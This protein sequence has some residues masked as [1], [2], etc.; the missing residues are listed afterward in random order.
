MQVAIGKGDGALTFFEFKD[1]GLSTAD[2]D[3]ARQHKQKGY[4]CSETEVPLMSLDAL[5]GE[6]ER[7][8]IHWLKLDVEGLEKSILESWQLAPGRPWIL[9]IESTIPSTQ[10]TTHTDWESLVLSKGYE[11]AYFDGLNRFYVS[12]EQPS[13]KQAFN[14]PPNIFDGFALSGLASQ[15]FCAVVA[16]RAQKAEEQAQHALERAHDAEAQAQQNQDRAG[17]AET[18]LHQVMN[19]RSWRLTAP[20]RWGGLR[21]RRLRAQGFSALAKTLI[22]KTGRPIVR[23]TLAFVNARPALR[24]R[25]VLV[26]HQLGLYDRLRSLYSK[27]QRLSSPSPLGAAGPHSITELA[28]LSPHAL[29]VYQDL[30]DAIENSKKA[31]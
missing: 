24:Q 6:F 8:P 19:S 3:I 26:I 20:L 15:P 30:E 27:L 13:L 4:A 11:F 12:K 17:R 5:L 2:P 28:D 25:C 31:H 10:T 16:S 22:K 14:S 29:R 9:V 23:R 21:A 18:F 7:R 1:T